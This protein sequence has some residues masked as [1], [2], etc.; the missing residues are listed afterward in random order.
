MVIK[1]RCLLWDWT[2]SAGP[3]N[4]GVPWALNQANFHPTAPLSSLSNWNTWTPPELHARCP[5]RPMVHLEA[6]LAGPDWHNIQSSDQP[7]IHFFNEPDKNAIPPQRAADAWHTHMVPLRQ[8]RNKKLVGPS[9]SNDANGQ[10]WLEEFMRLVEAHPPDYV[11]LHYYGADGDACVRYLEAMHDRYRR[12]VIVSEIASTAREKE[13]VEAFTIQLANFM[14]ET[15]W[16]FE[17]GFFGCMRKVADG[18]VSP[19]AQLMEPDGRFT[20]LMMK[21]QWDQPMKP[22]H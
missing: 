22:V 5:F 16:V 13:S 6:Q 2:N 18:F 11:G 12:P 4:P 1:K 20:D 14:D 21:L 8:H 3:N 7:L 10:R 15:E 17:Y 19:A 9:V